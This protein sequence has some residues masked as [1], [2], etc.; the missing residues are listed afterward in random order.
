MTRQLLILLS[1][2]LGGAVAGAVATYHLASPEPATRFSA[3]IERNIDDVADMSVSEA[4]S[5]RR[6]RYASIRTIEDTL[7]LPTDF[8]ETEALYVIAGRADSE[9][10][11]DLIYQAEAIR[12]RT[13]RMAALEILFLRMTEL[14][15]RSALA[16]ARSPTFKSEKS[17]ER[18]VW[19]AW[20]RLDLE[21]A[22]AEAKSGTVAQQKDAAQSLYLSLRG[23]DKSRSA[24]IESTLG[25]APGRAARAQRMYALADESPAAAIQ[26]IESLP[27]VRDQQEQFHSLAY[28]L[29]RTG[30][31]AE[32]DFGELIQSRTNRRT[33]E[34][35]MARY[36][37]GADPQA[38]LDTFLAGNKD[39]QGRVQA[40]MALQQLAEQDPDAA[41]AWA[42]Q[43]D[44]SGNESMLV[45]VITQIGQ[46]DP[47]RAL[48]EAQSIGNRQVQD[49]VLMRI[50][51]TAAQS[52]PAEASRLIESVNDGN[53]RRSAVRQVAAAWA[54]SDITG[55]LDWIS[56]LDA[57]DQGH[58]FDYLGQSLVRTDIDRAMELIDQM[59][60]AGKQK[61]TLQIAQNLAQQRGYDEAAVFIA[62]YEGSKEY[63]RLQQAALSS[64]A[65]TDPGR[66]MQLAT[67]VKDERTRDSLYVTIV[68]RQVAED[69]QL[70][71]QSLDSISNSDT[72][73]N[74]LTQLAYGWFSSDPDSAGAWLDSLPRG[75]ERD[76]VILASVSSN[77]TEPARVQKL[78]NSV[79]DPAVR[80]Q[81]QLAQ[82][83][84]LAQTDPGAA[85]RLLNS[86]D[87]TEKE[88]E[89]YDQ[90]FDT[91]LHTQRSY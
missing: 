51:M 26:Y 88:L 3:P 10:L 64:L 52:D 83:R 68:G 57:V 70:A 85:R 14:D 20:G 71:L 30:R 38:A 13:D 11:Q 39:E 63:A 28:H 79:S 48:A 25:V 49:Q 62:Q 9:G 77:R 1:C 89:Q 27:N 5:H 40:S 86:I 34:R 18:S 19:A 47:L 56:T 55:A 6:D 4:E 17:H 58:A 46:R 59:P 43:N 36:R 87:L 33:F 90:F 37:A 12:D 29:N 81:A 53:A 42:R 15:P 22:L 91:Y 84:T 60:S 32:A 75:A 7:A 31:I 72:R 50:V 78:I 2:V 8:A 35:S 82:V 67:T 21:Q 74:A 54:Q 65:M 16:I 66:A 44:A 45:S 80:K 41:L 76:A 69:P 24:S 73:R 61:L 23:R